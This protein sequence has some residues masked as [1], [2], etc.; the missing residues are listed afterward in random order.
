MHSQFQDTPCWLTSLAVW[1]HVSPGGVHLTCH[2]T[3]QKSFHMLVGHFFNT[4]KLCSGQIF[5]STVHP[6]LASL[7]GS[8]CPSQHH[9]A[10][11]FHHL[12]LTPH[13]PM[14]TARPVRSDHPLL[15][16]CMLTTHQKLS[17][18]VLLIHKLSL[19]DLVVQLQMLTGSRPLCH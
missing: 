7:A 18:R 17:Y 8:L 9:Q 4:H 13:L 3:C 1:R 19:C 5:H 11:L 6:W 16:R 15:P 14:D 10:S 2:K 12:S